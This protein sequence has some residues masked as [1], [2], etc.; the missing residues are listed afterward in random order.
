MTHAI[1]ILGSG[2]FATRFARA[3][4]RRGHATRLVSR[5][6]PSTLEETLAWADAVYVATPPACHE[7]AVLAAA[8]RGKPVLLEKPVEATLARARAL[9]EKLGPLARLVTVEENYRFLGALPRLRDEVARLGPLRSVRVEV[10]RKRIPGGWRI[11]RSLAGG[12]AILD[13][14]VHYVHLLRQLVGELRVG[15]ATLGPPV[16]GGT[17][18]AEAR[19]EGH[20]GTGVP[21]T[22]LFA[23]GAPRNVSSVV[24]EGERTLRFRVGRPWLW[25]TTRTGWPTGLRRLSTDMGHEAL[26]DDWLAATARGEPGAVTLDEGIRDLEVAGAREPGLAYPSGP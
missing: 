18:E 19:V 10:T 11:D 2:S 8:R 20:V 5:R 9:R 14:G 7:D 15:S 23:W 22:L 24:F 3:F 17:V 21:F 16:P 1:A 13:V 6:G 26:V 12:G 4:E 25:R